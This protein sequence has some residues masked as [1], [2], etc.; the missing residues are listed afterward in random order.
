MEKLYFRI[1]QLKERDIPFD[2]SKKI[3]KKIMF[4]RLKLPLLLIALLISNFIF[5][6]YKTY[7][8]LVE[9]GGIT[10]LK[11]II[12]DF[13]IDWDYFFESGEGLIETMPTTEI[14]L[15][16][17]TTSSI[18]LFGLYVYK[19]YTSQNKLISM[20]FYFW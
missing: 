17:I 15:L 18:C 1:K 10:I 16:S 2:I 13:Q 20:V 9:T 19:I 6:C 8:Q 7:L 3:L 12:K 4:D 14:W 11:V 5:L